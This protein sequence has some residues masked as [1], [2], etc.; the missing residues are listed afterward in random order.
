MTVNNG[1]VECWAKALGVKSISVMNK[2][3]ADQSLDA[4]NKASGVI[5]EYRATAGSQQNRLEHTMNYLGVAVENTT[6]A[7]S[8]IRDT[9]MAKE[10]VTGSVASLLAQVGNSILAQSNSQHQSVVQLIH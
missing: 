8:H 9:D 2:S 5:S 7:E 4:I 6:S 3:R 10:M 1:T